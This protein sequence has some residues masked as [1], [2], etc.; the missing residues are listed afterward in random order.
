MIVL[1]PGVAYGCF[2]LLRIVAE[3]RI[4]MSRLSSEIPRFELLRTEDLLDL[5]VR[6][7]WIRT[8][9]VGEAMLAPAGDHLFNL[10]SERQRLRQ[11]LVHYVQTE[12][13]DWLQ[14]AIDGRARCMKFG[15]TGI[16]Q[17]ISEAYLAEG[18]ESDVVAFW[19]LLASIARGQRS[20]A[21]NAIGRR[22]ERLSMDFEKQRT[23]CEPQWRS[24]ESNADGYD[25][26]SVVSREDRSR[27]QVEVKTSTAGIRGSF[28]LTR[29]EWDQTE[30]MPNH[31]LHLWDLRDDACPRLAIVPRADVAPH[32]PIDGKLGRWM[33]CE[34]PFSAFEAF[35]LTRSGAYP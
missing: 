6:M 7:N 15:P 10:G 18:Y 22:G 23:G 11:A 16:I 31:T 4:S 9:D 21:L 5:C 2:N 8:N 1:S 29:N 32:I 20:A 25:V 12:R 24:I 26:L 35:F 34:V 30:L 17:T 27:M 28:H 14:L 19:D 3:H 33:E 13:P